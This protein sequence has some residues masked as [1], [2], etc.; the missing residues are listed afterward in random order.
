MMLGGYYDETQLVLHT[1]ACLGVLRGVSRNSALR[2]HTT[3]PSTRC[4]T[5]QLQPGVQDAI[6]HTDG[7][8][9]SRS[10]QPHT[11]LGEAVGYKTTRRGNSTTPAIPHVDTHW[12][13]GCWQSWHLPHSRTMPSQH[14]SQHSQ[15]D[16]HCR[17]H[18]MWH[19]NQS[20][21]VVQE[22]CRRT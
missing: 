6:I 4:K 1:A 15:S 22:P 5:S 17:Q 13:A 20:L 7:L 19:H 21:M 18:V 3:A 2:H 10:A 8:L 11:W 9:Y 12:Q 14:P 16:I